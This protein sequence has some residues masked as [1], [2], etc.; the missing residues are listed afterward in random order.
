MIVAKT[1]LRISF[2][3]GGSDLPN[4]YR[5]KQG[6]CLSTTINKYMYVSVCKTFVEGFKVVYSEIEN[7]KRV[8]DI[9]HDRIRECLRLFNIESGLDI[10]S[11]AQIPTKGTGLGSSSTFTVGLLN[12]LYALRGIHVSRYD[13]AETAFDIEHNWCNEYLGKQDQYAA[14]FGGLNVFKFHCKDVDVLPVTISS[15]HIESLNDNILIYYTG[16]TRTATD[17]L[18]SYNDTS[19]SDSMNVIV[20]IAEVATSYLKK[21]YHDDFGSMLAQAWEHKKKLSNSV[22]NPFIDEM[23]EHAIKSGSL[24]GKLLGA[25]GGGFLMFY[26]PT[27]KQAKFRE[28]MLK[29]PLQE[30]DFKFSDEGSKIV[31]N[32]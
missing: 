32:S 13:L 27:N 26:V 7:V 16:K 21:G 6:M 4:Y 29:T 11:H 19:G 9:K 5:D 20:D 28:D 22:S 14:A 25:G 15:E 12:A 24:G 3:G 2:F 8:D 1:P 31:C 23:Y 30:Y 17:I 10:S 18:K